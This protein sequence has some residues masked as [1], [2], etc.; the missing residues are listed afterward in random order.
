MIIYAHIRVSGIE[1]LNERL[2]NNQ[3]KSST[4][5][6]MLSIWMIYVIWIT[7]FSNSQPGSVVCVRADE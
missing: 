6:F 2:K 3:N 4:D 7:Y 1:K 5:G